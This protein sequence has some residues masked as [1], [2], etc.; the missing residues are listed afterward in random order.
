MFRIALSVGSP[1]T[2]ARTSRDRTAPLDRGS[3]AGIVI[4]PDGTRVLTDVRPD[5]LAQP[6]EDGNEQV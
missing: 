2:P 6:D 4:R 1:F 5:P 3:I